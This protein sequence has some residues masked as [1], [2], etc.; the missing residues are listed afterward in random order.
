LTHVTIEEHLYAAGLEPV[1]SI[2]RFL[3]YSFRG[4]L[5]A[6]KSLAGA[7]LRMP[8]VWRMLGKQYLVVA[9]R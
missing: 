4:R 5:P 7:Y 2:P 6:S 8:P 1:R 9:E 3:P